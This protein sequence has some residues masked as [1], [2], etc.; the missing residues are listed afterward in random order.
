M[1]YFIQR[2]LSVPLPGIVHS[3]PATLYL[4]F[5]LA[6]SPVSVPGWLCLALGFMS[7]GVGGGYFA[8]INCLVAGGRGDWER[9]KACDRTC[10]DGVAPFGLAYICI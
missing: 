4:I 1:G 2:T 8:E 7:R 9:G 5:L 6:V 10:G 3:P